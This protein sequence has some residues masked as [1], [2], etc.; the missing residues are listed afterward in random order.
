MTDDSKFEELLRAIDEADAGSAL[1]IEAG[2][3]TPRSG[4]RTT[5]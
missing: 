1:R 3:A 2:T 4:G 5:G